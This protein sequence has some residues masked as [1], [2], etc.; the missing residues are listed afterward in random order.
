M[1]V[2]AGARTSYTDTTAQKRA[3]ADYIDNIN[4]TEAPLCKYLGIGEKGQGGQSKVKAFR[5]VN[6]PSTK[7]EWLED[8]LAPLATTL[9]ASA[10]SGTTAVTIRNANYCRSGHLLLLTGASGEYV[11]VTSVSSDSLTITRAWGGTQAT[12]AASGTVEIVSNAHVE[13]ETSVASTTT[14]VSAPYNY[15][16]IFE[17]Q[18][19]VTRTHS[20][21]TQYGITGEYDYQTAKKF[22]EQVK[23]MEK[24]FF[25]GQRQEGAA[26]TSRGMGG[27]KTFI[28]DN[29]T[30]VGS[31]ALTE[32]QLLDSIQSAWT[33]GGEPNL[34]V[35][36]AWV[37]RKINSFYES[38]VRTTRKESRGGVVIDT[39][40]TDFGS[41][42]VMLNRW[43]PSTEM[44]ILDTQYIGILPLDSFFEEELAKSGDYKLGHIVG[45]YSLV[46]RNDKAHAL[47]TGISTTA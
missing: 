14:D 21:V 43:C 29:T 15:T 10:T 18:V 24:T 26:T 22:K 17:D 41:F 9:A 5:I 34:I 45:E 3:I 20:K 23:L 1:T 7:V 36:N 35:C 12:H 40:D 2:Y 44:Y 11:L 39:I 6:W 28:T 38:P 8:T 30:A 4:P 16:Q 47:L 19:K 31:V 13:G 42:E 33:D 32:K 46:V 25:H 27:L 37:K